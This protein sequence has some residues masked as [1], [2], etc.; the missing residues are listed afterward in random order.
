VAQLHLCPLTPHGRQV[1]NVLVGH[2]GGGRNRASQSENDDERDA[3]G[4]ARVSMGVADTGKQTQG[5]R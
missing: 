1:I 4:C 2:L 5:N 3:R